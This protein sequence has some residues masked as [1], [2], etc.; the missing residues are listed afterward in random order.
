[1][2]FPAAVYRAG[3]WV[4]GTAAFS[5]MLALAVGIWVAGDRRVQASLASDAEI[6]RL[7]E[8]DFEKYYSEY[9]ATSFAAQVWT[10]NAWVAA[11][12]FIGRRHRGC[13]GVPA[14]PATP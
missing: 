10:N 1:M 14:V 12:C 4:L 5:V 8:V 7:V 2:S 6:R 13:G 11:L 3:R 9:A